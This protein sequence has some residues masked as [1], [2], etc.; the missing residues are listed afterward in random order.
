MPNHPLKKRN[1]NAARYCSFFR[2]Y[3]IN[4]WG[5]DC[6]YVDKLIKIF[7][8]VTIVITHI[9]TFDLRLFNCAMR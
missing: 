1:T 8:N 4:I 7:A 6:T 3:I 5:P 9:Q 2:F